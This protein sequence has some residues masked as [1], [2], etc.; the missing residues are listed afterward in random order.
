[1]KISKNGTAKYVKRHIHSC[2][3]DSNSKKSFFV[4]RNIRNRFS[5]LLWV[6]VI[7]EQIQSKK[8]CRKYRM[9][10]NIENVSIT[11][12]ISYLRRFRIIYLIILIIS[13][14]GLVSTGEILIWGVVGVVLYALGLLAIVWLIY[15]HNPHPSPEDEEQIV[16]PLKVI[17]LMIIITALLMFNISNII[18][19]VVVVEDYT[20]IISVISIFIQGTTIYLVYKLRE[21]LLAR[22][23][24]RLVSNQ[25]SSSKDTPSPM[26]INRV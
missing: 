2:T 22:H 14:V 18:Y 3:N 16:S 23:Q 13:I 21:K 19:T 1:M 7:G 11:E 6:H 9:L 5:N 15:D 26:N 25:Q 20:A 10:A 4:V 8:M 12:L 24:E 17:P